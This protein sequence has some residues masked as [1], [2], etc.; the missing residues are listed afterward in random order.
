[1]KSLRKSLNSSSKPSISTPLP[2][3]SK[4][5]NAI[6]P[7]QKVIRAL[8]P[9]RPQ[10]PQELPFK[11]GDFFYV[12]RDVDAAWYEAHNPV[13]GARGLVPKNMF[14]EFQKDNAP[15][16]QAQ[17]TTPTSPAAPQMG[18]RP[19]PKSNVF[20]AIV[21][22]DFQ[23]ERA[24]ELDAKKGDAIT[25]VAQS[26]REWFVAKPIGRL[27]RPGL[28]P[29]TFVEVHDPATGQ[30]IADLQ[31]LMDSGDLPRVED[32]KRQMMNY[33]QNSIALGVLDTPNNRQS[34]PNSPF[35]TQQAPPFPPM[36]QPPMPNQ[37]FPPSP[38]PGMPS[39]YQNNNQ[40]QNIQPAYPPEE[41]PAPKP[42]YAEYSVVLPEGLLLSAD[43]VTF[44]KENDDFWFRID[45][46]YQPY[47]GPDDPDYPPSLNLILFR[48]YNDFYDF[49]VNLLDTFPREAGRQPPDNRILPYMPGPAN[50]V[51]E[52]L[53]ATRRAELDDYIK[54]LCDLRTVGARHILEHEIVR[55][56]LALKPGDVRNPGDSRGA[57]V[58]AVINQS[59]QYEQG[60]DDYQ[61][62]EEGVS[63]I[64]MGDG[65][66]S[67]G[68][69]YGDDG[70]AGYEPNHPYARNNGGPA[71]YAPAEDL[72]HERNESSA[73]FS[74]HPY[75]NS[76]TT[77]P[78]DRSSAAS[79]PQSFSYAST[80][81]SSRWAPSTVSSSTSPPT[82]ATSRS[83]SNSVAN[84][85]PISS[86][87]PNPAFIKIKIFDRVQD[88]LVAIR[89][90]P[91]ISYSELL[92]K[93]RT[94]LND[95]GLVSLKYDEG[96]GRFVELYDDGGWRDWLEGTDRY[97]LYAD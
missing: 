32:W 31:A 91:R 52:A 78:I 71:Q 82:S 4:P 44:H 33:K 38:N 59:Q 6:T 5:S 75:A 12:V 35:V 21:M 92:D 1:M 69:D 57:E 88:D 24:D 25:V 61:G 41:P 27:G 66:H 64:S 15:L 84:A 17:V 80:Q 9:Y 68:S 77:S 70:G 45:A 79:P 2:V 23:A 3:V 28:I 50:D 73:S 96:Q 63:R 95:Q 39:Q 90:H 58:E 85:P 36:N 34:V 26:N 16:R 54:Q 11:K 20:Y 19:A 55:K 42:N 81:S 18:A 97:V 72:R 65:H 22:H 67:D 49:Q 30:A 46:A 14:E 40:Y 94:R 56:F 93:V 76:R 86:T 74:S 53:S 7:P 10:A 62:L 47:P 37:N 43:V 87:N 48:V 8:S 13:T 60:Q 89:V 51:D 83:R 29:V